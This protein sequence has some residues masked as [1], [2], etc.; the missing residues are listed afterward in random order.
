MAEAEAAVNDADGGRAALE[1]ALEEARGRYAVA[2]EFQNDLQIALVDA[3]RAGDGE[4]ARRVLGMANFSMVGGS[5]TA[6]PRLTAQP[7]D[8]GRIEGAE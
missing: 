4:E 3:R 7:F 8:G 6:L 1:A 2:I 5:E